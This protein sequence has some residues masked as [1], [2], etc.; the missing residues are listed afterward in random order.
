VG[1]Q[2]ISWHPEQ[3]PLGKNLRT[4]PLSEGLLFHKSGFYAVMETVWKE[5]EQ[6]DQKCS[7]QGSFMKH[8]TRG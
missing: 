4:S 8:N 7:G 1:E 5:A 3:K 2:E 6:N